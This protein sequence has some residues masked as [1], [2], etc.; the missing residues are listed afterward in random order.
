[1]CGL[2]LLLIWTAWQ[3]KSMSLLWNR[4]PDVVVNEL[5]C[6]M[7]TKIVRALSE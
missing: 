6:A 2:E 1:M 3:K 7:Y 5:S 4:T